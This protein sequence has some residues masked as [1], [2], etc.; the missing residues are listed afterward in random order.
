MPKVNLSIKMKIYFRQTWTRQTLAFLELLLEPK[1]GHIPWQLSSLSKL[2]SM[3]KQFFRKQYSKVWTDPDIPGPEVQPWCLQCDSQAATERAE[4]QG[5]W[6]QQ[7]R[8]EYWP[9]IGPDWSRDLNTGLWLVTREQLQ[10]WELWFWHL[11]RTI[12]WRE[13]NWYSPIKIQDYT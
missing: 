2:G 12:M 9:L 4:R 11:M 1:R 5:A 8:G 7:I 10:G 6:E 13:R 3:F